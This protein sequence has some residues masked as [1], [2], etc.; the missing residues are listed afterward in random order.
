MVMYCSGCVNEY[1]ATDVRLGYTYS[2]PARANDPLHKSDRPTTGADT[3]PEVFYAE[4]SQFKQEQLGPRF[5]EIFDSE[6]VRQ[7]R[8]LH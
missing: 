3:M 7:D 8:V 5:A 6:K 2:R 4:L 1:T